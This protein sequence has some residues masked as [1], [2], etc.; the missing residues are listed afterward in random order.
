M[1]VVP[2]PVCSTS[3]TPTN[4]PFS[5]I[6]AD[7]FFFESKT[8]FLVVDS[9]TKWLEVDIMRN[10]TDANKVIKKFTAIFA[11]FG[12]PDVLVT[13]GGPPFNSSHFVKFMERQGIRVMKSPPYNPSS[14]G[15]A[16]RMVR[17][18]KDVL[19]KFL[20]DPLIKSLDDDDRLT[21]FLANYRNTCSSSDERFPT[22]KLL[23]YRPKTLVDLLNPRHSYKDFLVRKDLSPSSK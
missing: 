18:V 12:L 13:D 1:S 9:Y 4:R 11:R 15:Q 17:L 10:G 20:L 23:S 5:R 19:K 14:N 3:W 22:E 7:F 16:E 8:Y 21:Y 6:H 2:K